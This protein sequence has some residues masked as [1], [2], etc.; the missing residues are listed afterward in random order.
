MFSITRYLP[1]LIKI[2]RANALGIFSASE[3]NSWLRTF[4]DK[5]QRTRDITTDKINFWELVLKRN[6]FEIIFNLMHSKLS[7]G[8][9]QKQT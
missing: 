5:K 4:I 9:E 1:N 3:G 8:K 2:P 6:V 7:N